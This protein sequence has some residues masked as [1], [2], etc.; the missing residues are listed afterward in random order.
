MADDFTNPVPDDAF[1]ETVVRYLDGRL[2]H[3]ELP[4]FEAQLAS[5]AASRRALLDVCLQMALVAESPKECL[6]S[7]LEENADGTTAN[8]QCGTLNDELPSQAGIVINL[9]AAV[10]ID[11]SSLVIYHSDSSPS[12]FGGALFSYLMA[13]LIVGMGLLAAWA[14]KLPIHNEIV[15]QYNSTRTSNPQSL[16]PNPLFLLATSSPLPPV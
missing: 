13:T 8:D 6:F 1:Y 7:L 9:Q 3:E 16:I 10:P 12:F 11:S 4:A 2:S 5:S 15:R 14:W